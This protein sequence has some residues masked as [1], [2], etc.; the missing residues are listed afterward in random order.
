MDC[1]APIDTTVAL[2]LHSSTK[3]R[4]EAKLQ[5]RN[6]QHERRRYTKP[7]ATLIQ[8]CQK[9]A[10]HPVVGLFL[11][12][13]ERL[14]CAC[15]DSIKQCIGFAIGERVN[16]EP[17]RFRRSVRL[18]GNLCIRPG[19]FCIVVFQTGARFEAW[20]SRMP[21]LWSTEPQHQ[22]ALLLLRK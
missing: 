17:C 11:W 2:T 5:G 20:S 3:T 12:P 16:Y 19:G 13:R 15:P 6:V 7:L 8:R 21:T 22:R 10:G 18:S 14:V 9:Y 4:A 1:F